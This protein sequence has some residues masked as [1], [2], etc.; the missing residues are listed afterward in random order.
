MAVLAVIGLGFGAAEP[1]TYTLP[2]VNAKFDYQIGAAYT[3]PSGVTVVSRDRT[4][5]P[6]AGL[7]NIC[8]VNVFQTQPDEISWWQT[9]HN[10]LLLKDSSGK[11]VVDGAWGEN[12]IDV[13]TPAKRT[14]VAAIVNGWIDGC[15]SKGFK[16]VEPDN[17]DS[18]ERSGGLLTK[19]NA[20][21]L[22]QLLAL[23]A[24]DKGLAIAQKNTTAL[25]TAGK[26]A[27]LDF[28][29]AEECGRYNECDAYTSVYGNNVIVIEYTKNAFTKACNGYG[30]SLSIVL[31]DLNVTAPGS[32]TYKYDA[33]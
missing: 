33:C 16:A 21:A 12:L 1:T 6:A 14:A 30:P 26:N 24:H 3:P 2:P 22:L 11:Y 13:S 20:V 19:A 29:I 15:A 31:R 28:A 4:A 18:Y 5:T 25:G 17:I 7:Y 8:Y 27:G 9:N 32:G 23:H 10:D